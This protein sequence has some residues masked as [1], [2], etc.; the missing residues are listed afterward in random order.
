LARKWVMLEK[1]PKKPYFERPMFIYFIQCLATKKIKIGYARDP[2]A[3]LT[4]IQTGCP[5]PLLLL[6]MM[7]GNR[8]VERDLHAK[9]AGHLYRGEW[10]DPAPEIIEYIERLRGSEIQSV[11]F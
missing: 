9:F 6:G 3:R 8:F 4:C 2:W 10:F 1:P 11:D 5:T 7:P